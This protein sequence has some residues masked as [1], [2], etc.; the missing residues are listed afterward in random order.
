M[1][2]DQPKQ[3]LELMGRPLLM[4]TIDA[5][6]NIDLKMEVI[7]VL[8]E[9]HISTWQ[10]LVEKHNYTTPHRITTGGATRFDSV[11]QGLASIEGE[12]IVAIHDG[13]RPLVS[14]EVIQRTAHAAQRSGNGVAAVQVKDSIRQMVGDDNKAVDRSQ[15]YA[16]QTPQ[17]FDVSLIK[18][19]FSTC[20]SNAFTDDASVLESAG[21][22]IN[23]VEGSYDNLKV[24]TP[25]DLIIATAILNK[26]QKNA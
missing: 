11:Q 14:K 8:P 26:R 23:L 22:K 5:F 7:L 21:K 16:I 6:S 19:A 18:Q 20:T 15:F 4:H 2:S 10:E 25:E 1:K 3:F 13:A 12:G 17:T 24:T 9:D